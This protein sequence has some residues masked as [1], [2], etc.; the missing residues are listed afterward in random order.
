MLT[1]DAATQQQQAQASNS[2]IYLRDSSG[3]AG[4]WNP[5]G[6]SSS[7]SSSGGSNGNFNGFDP[8][9]PP[10]SPPPARD[11]SSASTTA[12]QHGQG[13]T[14]SAGNDGSGS[15]GGSS[16]GGD[17]SGGSST[18]SQ[19]W[20]IFNPYASLSGPS[21]A[22]SSG[23][24]A[25]GGLPSHGQ[26]AAY[27][28]AD[29]TRGGAAALHPLMS[30]ALS[31]PSA[32]RK[33]EFCFRHG[34]YGIPK[35]H[36]LALPPKKKQRSR[37]EGGGG[38][39]M[40]MLSAAADFLTGPQV[41]MHEIPPPPQQQE[42]EAAAAE[43]AEGASQAQRNTD[44]SNRKGSARLK[45]REKRQADSGSAAEHTSGRGRLLPQAG[46]SRRSCAIL[47]T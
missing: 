4:G 32:A 14:M 29:P 36:P 44:G 3:F 43:T 1:W 9:A 47:S 34:A 12:Q 8:P 22:S 39:A 23:A 35:R 31:I 19:A 26:A 17:A 46:E 37:R 25:A 40:S 33:P 21:S 5:F 2:A 15:S 13:Y 16:S 45:V 42:A 41:V 6:S 10:S 24:L 38:G 28:R 7:S 20:S 18:G 11:G 30:R 27:Q